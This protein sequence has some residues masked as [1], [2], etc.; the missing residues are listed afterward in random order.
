MNFT[1][2]GEPQGKARPRFTKTGRAYTPKNTVEYENRVMDE[3]I[4]QGGIFFG[5]DRPVRMDIIA[6]FKIPKSVSKDKRN[7]MLQH[8]ILP[9]KRPDADNVGKCI[10][11]GCNKVAFYDDSQIVSMSVKKLYGDVPRVEVQITEV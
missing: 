11:D 3:Y 10:A 2:Y 5:K 8:E 9:T 4:K 1:V 7:R 6:Y